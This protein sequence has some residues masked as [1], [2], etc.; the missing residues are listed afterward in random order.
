MA[1][2]F[3]APLAK[4][5]NYRPL[6]IHYSRAICFFLPSC[7]NIPLSTPVNKHCHSHLCIVMYRIRDVQLFLEPEPLTPITDTFLCLYIT[8]CIITCILHFV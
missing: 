3:R 8:C 5:T 1:S 7:T 4:S 2:R 6:F